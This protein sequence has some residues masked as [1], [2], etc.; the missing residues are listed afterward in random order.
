M[1]VSDRRRPHC[2]LPEYGSAKYQTESLMRAFDLP[3]ADLH[4]LIEDVVFV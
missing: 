1:V 4:L 2:Y 3:R